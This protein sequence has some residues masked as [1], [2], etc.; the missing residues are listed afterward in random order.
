MFDGWS[1]QDAVLAAVMFIWSLRLA[2][3]FGR[4]TGR[5]EVAELVR[6]DPD[7]ALRQIEAG[8]AAEGRFR[9]WARGRED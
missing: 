7:G 5:D 2:Y 6:K 4:E 1:W 3:K 9:K 8:R